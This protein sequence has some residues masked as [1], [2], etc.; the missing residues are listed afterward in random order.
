MNCPCCGVPV[1]K[2]AAFCP[3]CSTNMNISGSVPQRSAAIPA[4]YKPI[5]PWGYIGYSLLFALPIVGFICLII[6]SFNGNNINR[7]N[8]ARS[9]FCALLI[10]LILFIAAFALAAATGTTDELIETIQSMAP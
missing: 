5:S 10:V 8:F 9:Y 6:Y 2:G 4:S 3:S 7:R 1:Q